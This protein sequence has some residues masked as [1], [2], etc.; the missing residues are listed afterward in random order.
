MRRF[1][2]NSLF[3]CMAI[4][5]A[6]SM[7]AQAEVNPDASYFGADI[8]PY[9]RG[10]FGFGN[11]LRPNPNLWY[12]GQSL[13]CDKAGTATP[14]PLGRPTLSLGQAW[15]FEDRGPASGLSSEEW[16][17]VWRATEV[18][19][20]YRYEGGR[21]HMVYP[22]H[23]TGASVLPS[24]SAQDEYKDADSDKGPIKGR[25]SEDL[26]PGLDGRLRESSEIRLRQL[27]RETFGSGSLNVETPIG[28]LP[29]SLGSYVNQ[30]YDLGGTTYTSLLFPQQYLGDAVVALNDAG[31]SNFYAN[32]CWNVQLPTD[33]NFARTG[34]HGG[35]SWGAALD[36]Q[37]AIK[38]VGLTGDI[39]SAW[40][41]VPA[42]A[43]PVVVAVIDTGLD[44]HHLDID[45]ASI[46]RNG[47][48]NPDNGVDDDQNGYVDDV[49][50][51]DFIG[52]NNRPWDFDG[53]GTL[54]TGIIAAA[55]NDAGIAGI[56]PNARI[57]VLK[58][59]GNFGTTRPSFIA[60]AIVY[61]VDNG[62]KVINISVGGEHANRMVQA[63]V[64]FA[65]Q[66]GV[67]VVAAAGNEGVE[68]DDYGPAGGE[69]VL[70]VGATHDDDRGTGF[71]NFGDRVDIAA[72]GVD[73][74]SLRARYTD[75]NYRPGAEGNEVYT[76]GDNYVGKDKR[77]LRASGTSFSAPIV[78]GVAS[79]LLSKNPELTAEQ[80]EQILLQTA[81]D[82]EKPGK[83]RYTGHGMVDARAALSVDTDFAVTAEI[84]GLELFPSDAPQYVRVR[85]TID[86]SD[87]KRAWMQI[88]PGENPG[89]WRFV[90]QKRK[91]PIVN[92][93]IGTIPLR[94]FNSSGLW[95]VVVNVEHKNGVVKRAAFPITV[96]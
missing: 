16:D 66:Q 80:V 32:G 70:T 4:A 11:S 37:W 68:L 20:E 33:P 75:A 2:R 73:V 5:I 63:A 22:I 35:N 95:Q 38:R 12:S 57:M 40:N 3:V 56:N 64:D 81:T 43:A 61:A 1:P 58:A 59:V 96:D 85:G 30:Q 47:G 74:L 55:H 77:Y 82:V 88:G 83:D 67:L 94:N 65:H 25:T 52:K 17:S 29:D 50:G 21:V 10:S 62:A 76:V 31:I 44:W 53:H 6:G 91:Y 13:D 60:E 23:D 71:A 45:P 92:G 89:G 8:Q 41:S 87:F 49:I 19:P 26:F 15:G 84:T 27:M 34:R 90:G 72:P 69:H 54:V 14:A 36:D 42:N 78:S 93:E 46:W 39:D 7:T 79:L 28:S 24:A 86:A 51:W 9:L 48:E 18:Y